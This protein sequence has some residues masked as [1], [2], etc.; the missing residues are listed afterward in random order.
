MTLAIVVAAACALL[1]I[2]AMLDASFE[3]LLDYRREAIADGA[4]YRLFTAHLVHLSG[5][6]AALDIA[7]LL[8]VAWIFGAAL[9]ARQCATIVLAAIGAIDAALWFLHPE[10]ER[11]AGLSG[12]LHAWFA[13]GA[14]G[15]ALADG[16]PGPLAARAWGA[17]LLIGLAI[18]LWLELH[19]RAFWL[20]VGAINVV[21]SAHRWGALA[22]VAC[23]VAIVGLRRRDGRAGVAS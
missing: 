1:A 13:A 19:D 17:A 18:K 22:G 2:V 3:P 15:W 5:T 23:G 6:H 7:G 9:S 21:T 4:L 8:L 11:Y 20:D 10:V 12:V 14:V 16:R